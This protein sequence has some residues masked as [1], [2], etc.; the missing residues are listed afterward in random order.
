MPTRLISVKEHFRSRPKRKT[1]LEK[2][3]QKSAKPKRRRKK[4]IGGGVI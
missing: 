4:T 3:M 2:A 1:A